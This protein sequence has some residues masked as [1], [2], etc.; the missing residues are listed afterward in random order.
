MPMPR[1]T[2]LEWR[3]GIEGSEHVPCFPDRPCQK[4]QVG[5]SWQQLASDSVCGALCPSPTWKVLFSLSMNSLPQCANLAVGFPRM[6]S[7]IMTT[8]GVV[9]LIEL[10]LIAMSIKYRLAIGKMGRYLG[11]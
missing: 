9:E 7:S 4:R 2:W 1:A 8:L 5:R 10:L 6:T 11:A 3:T